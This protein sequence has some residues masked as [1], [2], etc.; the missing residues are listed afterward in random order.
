M[1]K[2]FAIFVALIALLALAYTAGYVTGHGNSEKKYGPSPEKKTVAEKETPKSEN[3]VDDDM[4]LLQEALQKSR[5]ANELLQ[6]AQA[7]E[8]EAEE[9]LAEAIKM[10]QEAMEAFKKASEKSQDA[11]TKL[12]RAIEEKN[13]SK[14][15]NNETQKMMDEMKRE[16][17]ELKKEDGKEENKLKFKVPSDNVG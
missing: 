2:E 14:K 15:L 17:R 1:K 4:K 7:A 11:A 3:R 13:E 8:K 9:K 12:K 6:K 10:R 16:L 5:E